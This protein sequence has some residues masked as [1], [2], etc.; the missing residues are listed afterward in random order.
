[1][2][3]FTRFLKAEKSKDFYAIQHH[4]KSKH[5]SRTQE[6]NE[7]ALADKKSHYLKKWSDLLEKSETLAQINIAKYMIDYTE[8]M[9]RV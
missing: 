7:Q 9:T 8:R 2:R 4:N 1:M 3:E 6:Q 5:D